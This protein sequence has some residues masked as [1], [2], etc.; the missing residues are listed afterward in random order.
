MIRHLIKLILRKLGLL[1][2]VKYFVYG[3]HLR[4]KPEIEA[5]VHQKINIFNG[6]EFL[7]FP[8][9]K[10]L[11]VLKSSAKGIRIIWFLPDVG[12]G[13]GGHLNIFRMIKNLETFGCRSDVV[14]CNGSQW[15]TPK[16]AKEIIHQHFYKIDV[17]VFIVE[18]L[19]E[20]DRMSIEYDF[21]MA[22]SWQTAY[23]VRAYQNSRQK[24]YFVQ[25][26]EP[27][28]FPRGSFHSFSER[29]YHFGFFGVTAGDWL[30]QKLKNEYRMPAESF[31]F[32]YDKAIYNFKFQNREQQGRIF[33]YARPFTSRREFELGLMALL[34]FTKKYPEIEVLLAGQDISEYDIPFKHRSLGI[35]KISELP[36]IYRSCDAAL[37]LSATNLSLLPLE[38][39]ASGGIAII[40]RGAHNEWLDPAGKVFFYCDNTIESVCAVLEKAYL[41]QYN[42]V[43]YTKNVQKISGLT[44]WSKEAEKVY[45]YLKTIKDEA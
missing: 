14:L 19:E 15:K 27:F 20:L 24:G 17:T 34:R 23:F 6:L 30:K 25:D 37:I 3:L 39:A 2:A 44:S 40:N 21:A 9:R 41:K 29:T 12:I 8:E 35:L 26:F 7:E 38:V 22:T 45:Q 36:E 5:A 33:F 13:S 28:F 4:R 1:D 16:R 43:E 11:P 18:N 32:S 31:G 42:A 10:P